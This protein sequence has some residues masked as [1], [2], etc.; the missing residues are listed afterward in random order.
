MGALAE[1]LTE[2]GNGLGLTDFEVGFAASCYVLGAVLGS[3]VFGYLTDRFGRKKLFLLTLVLY[4]MISV[5][6]L[7][8]GLL[9]I[10]TAAL[11]AT[12]R[13]PRPG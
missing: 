3:L 5:C 7:G 2:P 1:R 4:L 6:Y 10:G 13:C 9:L 12:A 8:S 11:S